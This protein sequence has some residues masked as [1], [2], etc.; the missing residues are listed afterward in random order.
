MREVRVTTEAAT[1]DTA[2]SVNDSFAHMQGHDT[3]N[4]EKEG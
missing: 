1:V 4:K 2:E 3:S